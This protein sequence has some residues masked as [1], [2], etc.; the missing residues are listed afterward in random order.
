MLGMVYNFLPFMI[1][2]IQ[3]SLSKM[4]H[5]LVEASAD[6]GANPVQ[7]SRELSTVAARR[8]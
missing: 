1:L 2:Q 4:D 8:H 7:T 3:T 6:L 5:S